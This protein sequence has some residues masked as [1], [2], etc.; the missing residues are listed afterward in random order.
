MVIMYAA[1]HRLAVPSLAR[2]LLVLGILATLAANVAHGWADGPVGAVVAAWPAASLVGSHGLLLWLVRTAA[3]GAQLQE[4]GRDQ[5]TVQVTKSAPISPP[6][7]LGELDAVGAP[8]NEMTEQEIN[9]AAVAAYRES[10][11]G[12]KPLS[13]RKLAAMFG[14]TSRRWAR[15]RIAE[16]RQIG[17][18]HDARGEAAALDRQD[19]CQ[20]SVWRE[21][22]VR[23]CPRPDVALNLE[24]DASA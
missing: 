22:V 1:R 16:A 11:N 23:V 12:R 21:P 15:S 19:Q 24:P 7:V 10:L 5:M 8:V 3:D 2:W 6:T 14:K 20:R 18:G 13:E 9:D 4:A 17:D